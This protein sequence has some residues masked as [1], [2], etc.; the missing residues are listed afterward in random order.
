MKD[1]C[2]NHLLTTYKK[3]VKPNFIVLEIGSSTK[4]KTKDLSKYCKKIIGIEF[5]KE[6]IPK[7]FDKVSYLQGDWQKLT[8]KIKPNSIDMAISSH[9]IEHISND[10]NALNE[11]YTV[12][13]PNSC[14][15]INTP[16]R[17]RLI[18][19]IIEIFTSEKQF[20]YLEHV[21]EYTETDLIELISKSKFTKYK[22]TPLVFGI[23]AGNIRLCFKKVPAKFRDLANF[24]EIILYK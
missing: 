22:I 17:K 15:I 11:L 8:K 2:W 9:V 23:H 13:K 7:D 16:N 12:L 19:R 6:R 3:L 1:Y 21:R 4:Y 18:R 10:L 20:P 5:L 14:A 24:W